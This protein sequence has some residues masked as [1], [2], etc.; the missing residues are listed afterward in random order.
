MKKLHKGN[1]LR[2]VHQ[3]YRKES[4][5]IKMNLLHILANNRNQSLFNKRNL[6]VHHDPLVSAVLG[7]VNREANHLLK[8]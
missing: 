2:A 4:Q 8:E 7:T 5:D 1:D 6:R 3:T